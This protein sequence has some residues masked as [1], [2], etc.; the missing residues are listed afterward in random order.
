[1]RTRPSTFREGRLQPTAAVAGPA[2]HCATN[3]CREIILNLQQFFSVDLATYS[4]G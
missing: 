3:I 1:M 4:V 2:P